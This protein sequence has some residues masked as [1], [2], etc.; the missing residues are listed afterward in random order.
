MAEFPDIEFAE[1]VR[2]VQKM[3]LAAY[4]NPDRNGCPGKKIIHDIAGLPLPSQHPVFE[5][6]ISRCSPCIADVLAERTRIQSSRSV[7]FV[8]W[9]AAVAACLVLAF[10]G[11]RVWQVHEHARIPVFVTIN[12]RNHGTFRGRTKIAKTAEQSSK[13]GAPRF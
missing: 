10:I 5:H 8:R 9:I 13:Y 6:H 7:S 12:L 4:P 2:S 1:F 11:F 3:A